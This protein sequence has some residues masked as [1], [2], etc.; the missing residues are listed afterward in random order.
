MPRLCRLRRRRS[1]Q[2]FLAS[3]RR[4]DADRRDPS[5]QPRPAQG[6]RHRICSVEEIGTIPNPDEKFLPQNANGNGHGAGPKVR[7][8][9]CQIIWQHKLDPELPM[10]KDRSQS[11]FSPIAKNNL[12]LIQCF[13]PAFLSALKKANGLNPILSATSKNSITSSRRSPRSTFDTKDC[14]RKR[15]SAS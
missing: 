13:S 5:R 7:D 10:L 9:L 4:R 1:F 3:S 11:R 2:C 12:P 14:G 15:S 8:R 6:L